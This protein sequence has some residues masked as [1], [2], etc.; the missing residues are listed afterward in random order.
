[1]TEARLLRVWV[2][3]P[4]PGLHGL[5]DAVEAAGFEAVAVP[6]LEIV[7]PADA[8][9]VAEQ[10]RADLARARLAVFVSRNA[11]DWLWRLLGDNTVDYLARLDIVAVGPGTAAALQERHIETV[12]RPDADAD[13]E[14]LLALTQL[15]EQAVADSD[16]V[17]IRGQGGREL[18]ADTLRRRGA[19]VI[20]IEVYGR[21]RCTA[22]AAR[23]PGLW[24]ER[25]PA[26]IVV[27]SRAG[28]EALVAMTAPAD[29]PSLLATRL[30]CLG[31]RLPEQARALDFSQSI[32]VPAAGGDE[33]I[34]QTLQAQFIGERDQ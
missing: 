12:I 14:A 13:S 22:T 10:A 15:R 17:I 20:Y 21:Q 16:V 5:C 34:V 4:E 28:L 9:T 33:A 30:L 29:R 3:R 23:L 19:R 18:L 24:R 2:T 6:T 8:G 1:M 27:S 25:K 31:R 7:P 26:A 11:V 32:P